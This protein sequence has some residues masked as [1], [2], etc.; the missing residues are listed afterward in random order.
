VVSTDTG[1]VAEV[2]T[3]GENGLL[4]PP[5]EPEALAEAIAR[6]FA[7]ESLRARLREAAAPSVETYAPDRIYARLE[8]IL[9]EAARVTA[10]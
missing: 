7:D 8:E 1:G 4:V 9:R 6:Y 2:V 10:R 3:D 5:G